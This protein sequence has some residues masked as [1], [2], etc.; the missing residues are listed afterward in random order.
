MFDALSETS[1]ARSFRAAWSRVTSCAEGKRA[2][3]QRTGWLGRVRGRT[4][5]SAGLGLGGAGAVG[6]VI[7]AHLGRWVQNGAKVVRN[8]AKVLFAPLGQQPFAFQLSRMSAPYCFKAE[9]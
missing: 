8:G 4:G 1:G 2:R 9:C 7:G 3:G 6:G 5:P